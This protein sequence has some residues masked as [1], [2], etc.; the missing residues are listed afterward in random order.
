M[1][2]Q[3]ML[4]HLH[5]SYNGD[6]SG[7]YWGHTP[8]KKN[9]FR[10]ERWL[11]RTDKTKTEKHGRTQNTHWRTDEKLK[12]RAPTRILALANLA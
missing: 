6:K 11:L 5:R 8:K 1:M 7:Q 2:F 9:T 3:C 4:D 10:M 12:L